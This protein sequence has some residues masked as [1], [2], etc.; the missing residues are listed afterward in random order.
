MRAQR[1]SGSDAAL[2]SLILPPFVGFL[3]LKFSGHAIPATRQCDGGV[4]QP[5]GKRLPRSVAH[6]TK[7][8]YGSHSTLLG[9]CQVDP[10]LLLI[11]NTLKQEACEWNQGSTAPSGRS[12]CWSVSAAY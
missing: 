10:A 5:H 7:L 11:G 6:A 4:P 1:L 2:L 3:M 9:Y 12:P 8:P